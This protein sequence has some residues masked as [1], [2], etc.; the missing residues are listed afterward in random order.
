MSQLSD[1]DFYTKASSGLRLLLTNALNLF[2]ES[3]FTS[4]AGHRQGA[5]ILAG[6]A[7]EEAAKFHILLDAVRCPRGPARISHLRRHFYDHLARGI[8][9]DHYD[10]YPSSFADVRAW[11][12]N[13]RIALYLD[14]PE[15]FEWVF[16]N[17]I[18]ERREQQLY[19]DY[20]QVEE[21]HQWVAPN[22]RLCFAPVVP[23]TIL[24]V[25]RA[26]AKA[27]VTEAPALSV[28]ADLWRGFQISDS[29]SWGELHQKNLEVLTAIRDRGSLRSDCEVAFLCE[30]WAFP[31]VGLDLTEDTSVTITDLRRVRDEAE[32]RWIAREVGHPY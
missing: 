29:T 14:G 31:L 28:V 20:V 10:N 19:V 25:A 8:Y 17:R 23:T 18:A 7:V 24:A 26:L 13:S 15:G 4:K 11:A 27:G 12:N 32:A 9:A 22:R 30:R 3:V 1:A 5:V 16:R 2:R 6:L 21:D